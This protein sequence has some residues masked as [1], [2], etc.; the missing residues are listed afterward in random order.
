MREKPKP[1]VGLFQNLNFN[2]I[3]MKNIRYALFGAMIVALCGLFS[4]KDEGPGLPNPLQFSFVSATFNGA[5]YSA[6]PNY[7]LS[8]TYADNGT[9]T[10]YT[11]TGNANFTPTP[12][13]SG[14]MTV[15]GN[16]VTFSSGGDARTCTISGGGLSQSATTVTLT[17][18]LTKIDDGVEADEVG[19]YRYQME[20]K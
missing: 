16:T 10:G 14:T 20:V 9:P 11:A 18:S 19:E 2:P 6:A 4:C 12:G 3:Q 8:V 17:F 5:A 7:T 15:S 13:N 1:N